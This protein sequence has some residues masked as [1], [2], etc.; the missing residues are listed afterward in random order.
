[1]GR[2]LRKHRE[3]RESN[4][5]NGGGCPNCA[6]P[7]QASRLMKLQNE[8][9]DLADG[10]A[11]FRAAPD[12]PA[13]AFE[14]NLEDIRAFEAVGSGIS[15]FVGLQMHGMDLPLPEQLDERQSTQKAKEV[16]EALQDLQIFLVGFERMTARE[17]YST[18][19]NQTLWEGCYIRK[20]DPGAVTLIDVSHKMARSEIMQCLDNLMKRSSIH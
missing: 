2:Q 18:L 4:V 11:V 17:L 16:L 20:R 1:M 15:L 9:N 13:D 12:C 10:E 8:I 19:Y 5:Q 6:N 7:E 14:S 3:R